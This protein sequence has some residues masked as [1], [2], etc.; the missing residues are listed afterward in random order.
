VLL[1]QYFAQH[2]RIIG[3]NVDPDF[4]DAL[5]GFMVCRVEDLGAAYRR[6]P[7]G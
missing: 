5:D 7:A 1:R 4:S 6:S 2:A 3:F